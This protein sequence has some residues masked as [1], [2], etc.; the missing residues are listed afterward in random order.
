ME[1]APPGMGGKTGVEGGCKW[2]ESLEAGNGRGW[3][4]H[5]DTDVAVDTNTNIDVKL[6]RKKTKPS[7]FDWRPVSRA[8]MSNISES[9]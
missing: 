6:P 1:T 7:F 4:R 8:H 2:V 9:L 3:K 5:V